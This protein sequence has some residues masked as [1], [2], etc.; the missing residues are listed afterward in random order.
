MD[1]IVWRLG[2]HVVIACGDT[3][4]DPQV[5][6]RAVKARAGL[7]A[8]RDQL[9]SRVAVIEGVR[10]ALDLVDRA[11]VELLARPPRQ[12]PRARPGTGNSPR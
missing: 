1:A 7:R 3:L 8:E 10:G 12:N 5:A 6:E 4:R 11:T 2:R 9:L